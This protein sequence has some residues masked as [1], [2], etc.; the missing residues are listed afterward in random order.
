MVN[1]RSQQRRTEERK[2]RWRSSERPAR[3]VSQKSHGCWA[4][5]RRD[6]MN[7]PAGRYGRSGG[8]PIL[9]KKCAEKGYIQSPPFCPSRLW[10]L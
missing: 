5:C 6:P 1:R 7:S 9:R 10:Q 2:N 4:S 3:Q 8:D